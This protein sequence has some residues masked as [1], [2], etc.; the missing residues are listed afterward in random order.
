M[1][2]SILDKG[3]NGGYFRLKIISIGCAIFL[4]SFLLVFAIA[5][6]EN[7][8]IPLELTNNTLYLSPTQIGYYYIYPANP[9]DTMLELELEFT[10]GWQIVKNLKELNSIKVPPN[11][12]AGTFPIEVVIDIPVSGFTGN[13]FFLEYTL[14]DKS[15]DGKERYGPRGMFKVEIVPERLPLAPMDWDVVALRASYLTLLIIML[16]LST[17]YVS[18]RYY[19]RLEEKETEEEK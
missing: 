5:S 10:N 8:Y 14:Y 7:E 15:G 1:L 4:L 9:A 6:R 11:T 18:K 13:V 3:R 2:R 17:V 12:E 19:A 16:V